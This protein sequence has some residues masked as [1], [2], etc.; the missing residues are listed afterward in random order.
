MARSLR[1]LAATDLSAPARQAVV[2]AALQAVQSGAQL[3][4]L[5]VVERAPFERLRLLAGDLPSGFSEQI[6]SEARRDLQQLAEQLHQDL[7][8][9]AGTQV[10]CGPLLAEL[11]GRAETGQ[12]DLL[13]VGGRGERY[14]RHRVLGSTAERLLS[15]TRRPLLVVK[16]AVRAPYSAVLVPVDFSAASLPALQL[17]RAIAPDAEIILLHAFDVPFESK[18]RFGG[19]K[20]EVLHGYRAEARRAALARLQALCE[21]A[22]LPMER[23]RL[24][25]LRDEPGRCVIEQEHEQACDLI[26][27]GKHGE[28]KLEELL[29][30]STTRHVLEEAQ[31]DVL[32]SV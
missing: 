18:L 10:V 21:Q 27:I 26:V 29:L 28:N 13:V 22:Q 3:D 23:V 32:V 16:Q 9:S 31:C 6:K 1:F 20:E 4:L 19:I 24:L 15:K 2:R 5:H 25:V 8:I 17:A 12:A 11:E 7:D 14:L 30:G